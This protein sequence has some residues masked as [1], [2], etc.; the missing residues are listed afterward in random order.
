MLDSLIDDV[1][2]RIV[3]RS[4]RASTTCMADFGATGVTVQGNTGSQGTPTWTAINSGGTG[5]ANEIRISDNGSLTGTGSASWPAMVRPGST[6]IVGFYYLFTTDTAGNG[7]PGGATPVTWAVANYNMFR[8]QWDATGTFASAPILTAYASTA[9]AAITRGDNSILGGNVTDTGATARS[10]L[11]AQM[12][13]ANTAAVPA[14]PASAPSAP[15]GATD[16]T[17]GALTFSGAAAWLTA[18]QGLQ[19]DNDYI[20]YGATPTA[21]TAQGLQFMLALYTGPN[22]APSTYTPVLSM[23]YTWT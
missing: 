6:A 5:G 23:K 15:G 21:A 20:Q 17:T 7:V 16:G 9:H 10:Y 12:Y 8:L 19:G 4:S 13:G 18:W 14:F 1:V 22:M 11:K 3:S 2:D